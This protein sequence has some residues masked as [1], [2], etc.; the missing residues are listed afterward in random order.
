MTRIFLAVTALCLFACGGG[1]D[2]GTGAVAGATTGDAQTPPTGASALEAWLAQGAYKAWHCEPAPHA[3]RSPS[4]HGMDRVCSNDLLSA[5]GNGEF[6][7]GASAVKELYDG[8]AVNGYAVYRKVGAGGG[9]AWYWYE[10][11]GDR[12]NADG[13]GGSGEPKTVCASCHA[14]AGQD[15]RPGHDFVFTQ[16]R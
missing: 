7:I 12:L 11:I 4:P 8:A 14:S 16:V 3:A 15:G 2:P 1:S 5:H 10:K 13:T 6:P 9:D